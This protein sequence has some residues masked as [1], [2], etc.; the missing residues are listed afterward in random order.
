MNKHTS[1]LSLKDLVSI[2]LKSAIAPSEIKDAIDLIH[3]QFQ[4]LTQITAYDS[5]VEYL[6]AVPTAKGKALGL[7]HAAQCL[8]DYNRTHKFLKGMVAAIKEKQQNHP[9]ETIHILYAGCGPYAPFMTL[10]AQLFS[11][12]EI[13]FSLLEINK[14]SL[15]HAKELIEKLE[16]TDFVAD[17]YEAD[18]VTFSIP[19]AEKYHILFSE[20]L[21]ALLYREC[22]VPILFNLVPQLPE[23]TTIIPNN[24][25]IKGRF[26]LTSVNDPNYKVMREDVIIDV[27]KELDAY[28]TTNTIPEQ[29]PEKTI[30][31]KA[32]DIEQYHFFALD[33]EVHVYNDIW[34]TRNESSLTLA[35]EMEIEKPF[36]FNSIVFTY[37]MKDAIE[38]KFSL[39]D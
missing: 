5:K 26:S 13:Q 14:L 2:L 24:V 16:L 25:L 7:S 18:A 19:N 12:N 36:T 8:L 3:E 28:E 32:I 27:R 35:L 33:T 39:K 31:A 1:T 9:D 37:T 6:A 23:A 38:L 20:T 22:Y 34:L 15:H 29:L 17:F 4:E 21:D 30:D 10:V 11:P